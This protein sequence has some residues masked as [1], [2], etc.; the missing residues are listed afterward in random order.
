MSQQNL[1]R[2]FLQIEIM[3]NIIPL[4]LKVENKPKKVKNTLLF[5]LC[6]IKQKTEQYW[7]QETLQPGWG[8][9]TIE[10]N[11]MAGKFW[12]QKQEKGQ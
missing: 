11:I 2:K 5:I 7:V 9:I 4:G 6:D 8:N 12:T 1:S 10:Q 3:K